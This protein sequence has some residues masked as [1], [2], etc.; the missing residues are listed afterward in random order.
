MT[1]TNTNQSTGKGAVKSSSHVAYQVRQ[2]DGKPDFWNRIGAAFPHRD[3]QGFNIQ[4]D[5]MP[6]KG[7]IVLRIV[8]DN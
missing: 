5:A 7:Q 6:L 2:R 4:L 1:E 3:G 8:K